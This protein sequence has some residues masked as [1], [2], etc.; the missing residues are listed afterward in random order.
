MK[1]TTSRILPT[2]VANPV[3]ALLDRESVARICSACPQAQGTCAY[4][5]DALDW[6]S[7][8]FLLA[9]L[10]RASWSTPRP[11]ATPVAV[12][13]QRS[14]FMHVIYDFLCGSMSTGLGAFL[15]TVIRTTEVGL[16]ASLGVEAMGAVCPWALDR[17]LP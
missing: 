8:T 7:G 13:P 3:G 12:A 2:C 9:T 16:L 4:R 14:S 11:A 5:P 1:P 15:K 17:F 6:T 10:P